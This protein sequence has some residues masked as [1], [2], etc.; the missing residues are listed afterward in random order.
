LTLLP[1]E[2]IGALVIIQNDSGRKAGMDNFSVL[3]G[4]SFS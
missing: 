1:S 3:A 2:W 4:H